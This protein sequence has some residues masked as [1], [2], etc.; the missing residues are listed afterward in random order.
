MWISKFAYLADI[1]SHLNGLDNSLQGYCINIFTVC[2]KT[3]AFKKIGKE[4]I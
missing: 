1:F 3:N 4:K 2:S